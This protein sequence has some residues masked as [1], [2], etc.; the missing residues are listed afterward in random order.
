MK[1]NYVVLPVFLT[2]IF[3]LGTSFVIIKKKKKAVSK[4]AAVKKVSKPYYDP[5]YTL[6]VDKSD[7]ELKVYD[8]EG[9]LTTYPVVFGNK[10]L[11]DKTMQGDRCTPEGTFRI[12]NKNPNHKWNKFILFDYPNAESYQKFNERKRR[13]E[14]P[15]NAEIGSAIGIHG[16]WPGSEAVVDNYVN[17]TEGCIS[18]KNEDIQE[19]FAMLPLYT[20]LV[21]QP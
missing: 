2:A 4:T 21:I 1:I 14:I 5:T 10:S 9:W 18:M 8:K 16:T 17:W 19:L 20:K 6:V 7:Y 3:F 15:Q 13:G 12:I 11:K